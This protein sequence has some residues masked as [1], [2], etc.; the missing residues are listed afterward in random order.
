VP[1]TLTANFETHRAAHQGRRLV[2]GLAF[3]FVGFG[4]LAYAQDL[5]DP[6]TLA[7]AAIEEESEYGCPVDYPKPIFVNPGDKGDENG[8]GVVCAGE[9]GVVDNKLIVGDGE[10]RHVSGHGNFFDGGK[11]RLQDISF[12]FHGKPTD[13]TGAA[14]GQF[15]FHDQTG[16]GPDLTVHGEVLCLLARGASATLIG[17]VTRSNDANLPVDAVV[18][19]MTGDNG[20]GVNDRPDTLS[21]PSRL[22]IKV[23]PK[24]CGAKLPALTLVDIVSGNIQVHDDESSGGAPTTVE[25]ADSSGNAPAFITSGHG[26][27]FDDGKKLVQDISFSFHALGT[28]PDGKIV[29]GVATGQFEYH[30]QTSGGSDMTVHGEVLCASKVGNFVS[31][32]GIVTRSS[33]KGVPVN[34]LVAWQAEDNGEGTPDPADR[35]SRLSPIGVIKADACQGKVPILK[36]APIVGGNI[37]IQ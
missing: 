29:D 27:F 3:A 7:G 2:L 16:V 31:L 28:A 10:A 30:D 15:E 9:R 6:E 8:D 34:T 18:A 20:E 33:D 14:K 37:Q 24:L 13:D 19:W 23:S 17:V 5:D 22:G 1:R 36:L 11:G 35:V 32:V 25:D 4:V 12:S 21:R 26:N